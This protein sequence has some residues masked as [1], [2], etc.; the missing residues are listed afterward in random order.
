[1]YD[2]LDTKRTLINGN[3]RIAS[4]IADIVCLLRTVAI[5]FEGMLLD[6]IFLDMP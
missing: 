6:A 3:K 5:R 1:M 2:S 4:L